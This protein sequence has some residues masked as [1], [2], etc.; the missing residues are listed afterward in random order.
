MTTEIGNNTIYTMKIADSNI[1]S[2][3]IKIFLVIASS[4]VFKDEL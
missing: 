2:H 4:L 3:L 1:I